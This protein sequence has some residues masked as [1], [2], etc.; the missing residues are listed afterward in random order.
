LADVLPVLGGFDAVIC[1]LV[2]HCVNDLDPVLRVLHGQLRPAGTLI[3][4]DLHPA[5]FAVFSKAWTTCVSAG[6]NKF[7]YTLSP[8]CPELTLFLHERDQLEAAFARNGFELVERLSPASPGAD[9]AQFLYY[10]LRS[11]SREPELIHG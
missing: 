2:L 1:N 7:R 6:G 9:L 4:S 10:R 3:V 8:D 5:T 11:V